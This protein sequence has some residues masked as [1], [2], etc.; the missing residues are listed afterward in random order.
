MKPPCHILTSFGHVYLSAT[1]MGKLL[2]SL[3]TLTFVF[4]IKI[5]FNIMAVNGD[6]VL[7]YAKSAVRFK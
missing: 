1:E 2:F 5:I 4:S 7:R 3:I 6:C